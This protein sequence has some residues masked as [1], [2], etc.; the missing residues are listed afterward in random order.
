MY[1]GCDIKK[2]LQAASLQYVRIVIFLY[3]DCCKLLLEQL[4]RKH[5]SSVFTW[6]VIKKII[7]SAIIKI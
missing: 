3:G 5:A 7:I 1:Y 4:A 6:L 2:H